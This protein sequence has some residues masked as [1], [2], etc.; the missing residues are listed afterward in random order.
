MVM[1]YD[2]S[3]VGLSQSIINEIF[4]HWQKNNTCFV[5]VKQTLYSQ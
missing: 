4:F 2:A 3:E 5:G 1:I